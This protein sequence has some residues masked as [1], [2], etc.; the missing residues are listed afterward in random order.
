LPA[1]P[2]QF[3]EDYHLSTPSKKERPDRLF[4]NNNFEMNHPSQNLP[5]H[6]PCSSCTLFFYREKGTLFLLR[7]LKKNFKSH[8]AA[9]EISAPVALGLI[10]GRKIK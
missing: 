5:H 4:L 9:H 6:I 8:K 7:I 10:F 2:F 1:E 3:F